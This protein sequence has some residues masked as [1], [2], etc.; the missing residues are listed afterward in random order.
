MENPV[1]GGIP[2]FSDRN[3]MNL[4]FPENNYG[5]PSSS[6]TTKMLCAN[7]DGGGGDSCQVKLS[8][9][10]H[11][12]DALCSIQGGQVDIISIV[13]IVVL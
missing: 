5:Y 7:V 2:S 13:G 11:C 4:S 10:V 12:T 9:P 3:I 1:Y 6:I 8:L